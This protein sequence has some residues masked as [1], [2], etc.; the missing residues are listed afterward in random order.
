MKNKF[1]LQSLCILLIVMSN[2]LQAR[3][4]NK[5]SLH[6]QDQMQKLSRLEQQFG[7]KMN[8]SSFPVKS[9]HIS[10]RYAEINSTKYA[11]HPNY[12][13]QYT[14]VKEDAVEI[15]SERTED[16]RV[17]LNADNTYSYQTIFSP[18]HYQD[19]NGNWVA[20]DFSI[21]QNEIGWQSLQQEIP[22]KISKSG[23]IELFDK[24]KRICKMFESIK[25]N[26]IESKSKSD[27]TSGAEGIYFENIV[28]NVDRLIHFST[29][30]FSN[31]YILN[32]KINCLDQEFTISE[33]FEVANGYEIN[34]GEGVLKEGIWYGSLYLKNKNG[35]LVKEFSRPFIFDA[36]YALNKKNYLEGFYE[37]KKISENR[38]MITMHVDNNW[39]N[40]QDITYPIVIDPAY[41]STI[42]NGATCRNYSVT[43][44]NTPTN[45][46]ISA[47][48]DWYN[49]NA[50]VSIPGGMQVTSY[51]VSF[52]HQASGSGRIN[53]IFSL[54]RF[55]QNG[56]CGA[57]ACATSVRYPNSG[58]YHSL[59]TTTGTSETFSSTIPVPPTSCSKTGCGTT[60]SYKLYATR[61][62]P[63]IG[64]TSCNIVEHRIVN[65]VFT[66]NATA[67]PATT[68][69][70]N[71]APQT[72]LGN[73]NKVITGMVNN[74]SDY[75]VPNIT[76]GSTNITGISSVLMGS[77]ASTFSATVNTPSTLDCNM[78]STDY[79]ATVT[80][81]NSGSG[82]CATV[83]SISKI[84]TWYPAFTVDVSQVEV[85]YPSVAKVRV[86]GNN[87]GLCQEYTH[88]S[89]CAT[90]P[91]SFTLNS[92]S[93]FA[94]SYSG[95]LKVNDLVN[96]TFSNIP[97]STSITCNTAL[98][99][100][101]SNI[102]VVDNYTPG[103]P[104]I[105]YSQLD[106]RNQCGV[107]TVIRTW[108]A[109]DCSGNN[110]T[111]TQTITV[112]QIAG[113][114]TSTLT[115]IPSDIILAVGT[116]TP[117]VPTDVSAS[118]FCGLAPNIS[119]VEKILNG[120]SCNT[121][122]IQRQ[123]KLYDCSGVLKD[124]RTQN[125]TRNL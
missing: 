42:S 82:A 114:S 89:P 72:H 78:V 68:I 104:T 27:L 66:V 21:S 117:P 88:N 16:T 5:I 115:N 22:L 8:L 24:D 47:P 122:L 87:G 111:A 45:D 23:L 51:S 11:N 55:T 36:K 93:P 67:L 35:D 56:P 31:E 60:A 125:I 62:Y 120:T 20:P 44:G 109:T 13:D 3:A 73:Y 46:E 96:P 9:K 103:V 100:I 28:S 116:P 71:E 84:E 85:A 29:N 6:D 18:T 69:V 41:T 98:P 75:C 74:L 65:F 4:I 99:A 90:L 94:Q 37:L 64:A 39:L 2:S 59:L 113:V 15:L 43:S 58:F 32:E 38:Y 107:G 80:N 112:N 105:N 26:G 7:F 76:F 54:G 34:Y 86:L 12:G 124:T 17:F 1:Y 30:E 79:K 83:S 33:E 121:Q 57:T 91:Y 106:N 50:T 49:N 92:G 70:V 19:Q 52:A 63:G 14:G 101:P 10:T 61:T 40:S 48:A 97:A 81:A 102:S 110:S 119:F 77:D 95:S 53:D 118:S 108:V 123:W 25:I